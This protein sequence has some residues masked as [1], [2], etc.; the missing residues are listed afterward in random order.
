[1]IDQAFFAQPVVDPLT[2]SPS[3]SLGRGKPTFLSDSYR[4]ERAVKPCG[5]FSMY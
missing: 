3:P 2:P 4:F 5:I 1:L